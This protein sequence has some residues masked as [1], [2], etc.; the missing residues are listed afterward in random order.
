MSAPAEVPPPDT[1]LPGYECV[2]GIFV[3]VTVADKFY[4]KVAGFK[5]DKK[6]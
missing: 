1:P 4:K 3:P 6:P 2:G 5:A